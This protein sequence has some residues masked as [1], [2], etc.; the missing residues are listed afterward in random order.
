MPP[1]ITLTPVQSSML[2]AQ[3]YDPNTQTLAVK[4]NTGATFH[5]EGVS[6]EVADGL[7]GAD[8]AGKYFNANIRGKFEPKKIEPVDNTDAEDPSGD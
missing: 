1:D 3:G 6:Q 7:A 5:Y 2:A 4:F 8:S